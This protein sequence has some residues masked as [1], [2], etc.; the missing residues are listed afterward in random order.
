MGPGVVGVRGVVEALF[1]S[2]VH[3]R[4]DPLNHISD[5]SSNQ[6]TYSSHVLIVEL[7]VILQSI[8]QRARF[9]LHLE[10]KSNQLAS[11][12]KAKRSHISLA[13][14]QLIDCCRWRGKHYGVYELKI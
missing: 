7:G 14:V 4:G 9:N 1:L 12:R 6:F 5:A 10:T 13:K 8:S 3:G 11:L 2:S